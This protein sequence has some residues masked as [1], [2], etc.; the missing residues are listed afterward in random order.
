MYL[1]IN[2]LSDALPLESGACCLLG[3]SN[4]FRRSDLERLGGKIRNGY[5]SGTGSDAIQTT[6][7][8]PR[9]RANLSSHGLAAFSRFLA[10]DVALARALWHELGLRPY[11]CQDVVC[12]AVGGMS[13]NDY[14]RRRVRWIRLRRHV[15]PPPPLLQKASSKILVLSVVVRTAE[16]LAM[17]LEPFTESVALAVIAGASIGCLFGPGSGTLVW[18]TVF[19]HFLAWFMVDMDVY[20]SLA[21]NL[22]S[23]S[24]E[25]SSFLPDRQIRNEQ[26]GLVSN[27]G[28]LERHRTRSQSPWQ[29]PWILSTTKLG[30]KWRR[31]IW[32]WLARE[33][34]AFP[35]HLL[36]LCGDEVV[37][38]GNRYRLLSGGE[39]LKVG[40]TS[41]VGGLR[42]KER[43]M[44]NKREN[45]SKSFTDSE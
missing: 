20:A 32:A 37:W 18:W 10:E 38:R 19:V 1:A 22:V 6:I 21:V 12:N 26:V 29:P 34:L 8:P 41:S 40:S 14:V 23:D 4:L 9:V 15:A 28:C 44:D 16:M 17:I 11:L 13:L 2:A 45:N 27:G 39:A 33:L 5:L 7:T 25:A 31:L 30:L 24:S 42:K 43:I 3:K 36:A 35:I